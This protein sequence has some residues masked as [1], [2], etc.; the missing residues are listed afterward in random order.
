VQ[1]K[2]QVLLLLQKNFI[3]R[4]TDL[5]KRSTDLENA[6]QTCV[7]PE[8]LG[9]RAFCRFSTSVIHRTTRDEEPRGSPAWLSYAAACCMLLRIKQ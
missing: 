3:K 8:M 1:K 5:P 2:H 4:S 7:P 6:V 9:R